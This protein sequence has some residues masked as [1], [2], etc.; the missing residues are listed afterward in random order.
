MLLTIAYGLVQISAVPLF[1]SRTTATVGESKTASLNPLQMLSPGGASVENQ[2]VVLESQSARQYAA[3]KLNLTCKPVPLWEPSPLGYNILRG[4]AK[5][6]GGKR[7]KNYAVLDYPR[8]IE[9]EMDYEKLKKVALAVELDGD[10]S[11][12]LLR[13][14]AVVAEGKVG[15]ALAT[16]S[17]RV[18]LDGFTPGVSQKWQLKLYEPGLIARN[19]YDKTVIFQITRSNAIG[20][21]CLEVHPQLAKRIVEAMMEHVMQRDI[22]L[23]QASSRNQIDYLNEQID[24]I[25]NELGG[26]RGDLLAFLED[27][28]NLVSSAKEEDIAGSFLSS[29]ATILSLQND[30]ATVNNVLNRLRSGKEFVGTIDASLPTEIANLLLANIASLERN[31]QVDLE[32]KTEEHPDIILMRKQIAENRNSLEKLLA[33]STGQIAKRI[34]YYQERLAKYGALLSNSPVS[35]V[36]VSRLESEITTRTATLS[37]LYVQLQMANLQAISEDSAISILDPA[38]VLPYPVV[39]RLLYV[40]VMSV[41]VGLFLTMAVLFAQSALDKSL[42]SPGELALKL[43]ANVLATLDLGAAKPDESELV[44][45]G[46]KLSVILDSLGGAVALID[47]RE[48]GI[49]GIYVSDSAKKACVSALEIVGYH[50]SNDAERLLV[51]F[52]GSGARA[53][54]NPALKDVKAAILIATPGKRAVS[55]L[56]DTVA[57]CRE[58][59]LAVAGWV[60]A[61]CD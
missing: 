11:Y 13:N 26:F 21:K 53:V 40:A 61:V 27:K 29:E 59:D 43:K 1:S 16:D 19:L 52:V 18:A 10:G 30:L 58:C 17:F 38:D 37:Q 35:T 57:A 4:W 55:A 54:Y 50:R 46:A 8:V 23:R 44:R 60:F 28:Q 15:E 2:L 25:K 42:R 41:F 9:L 7:P 36:E 39:P 34:A 5:L 56:R 24:T 33:E 31:V 45:L 51:A 32:T 12:R 48:R 3:D 6:T 49:K 22:E 14:G 47:A 20:V